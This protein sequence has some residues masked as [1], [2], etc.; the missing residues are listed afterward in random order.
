MLIL[1]QVHFSFGSK[2]VLSDY[3]LHLQ[4]GEILALMGASG[5]GKS[6][7]LNLAAGLLQPNDGSITCNAIN[8]S[9]AF[10]EPR[11]F[12]WLNALQNVSV[13]LNGK[14]DATEQ[15]TRALKL[16]E[17]EQ[18]AHLY[19]REL[20]GGMKS[21]VSLARAIAHNGDLCLLDEPFAALDEE[22]RIRLSE[23]LRQHIKQSG[24]S[25]L[26]VTHQVTDAERFADR[27]VTL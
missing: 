7:I 22:L 18:C 5:V 8:I 10:Q 4:K 19:P 26:L 6:T 25:C 11:L 17:L 20:S 9:Y 27:I 13:V 15:A 23:R 16:V 3:S 12:P 1:D 24:A 2:C 14:D 21:R